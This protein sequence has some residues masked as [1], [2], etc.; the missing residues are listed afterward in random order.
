MKLNI[1]VIPGDGAGPEMVLPALDIL[2]IIS[3]RYGHILKLTEVTACGKGIEEQGSPLPEE[4]QKVCLA[5]DA[6]LLGNVG[7][8]KYQDNPFYLRPEYGL[9]KLR[10]C[11]KVTTNIRPVRLYAPLCSL[12]PLKKEVTERGLDL[13][14][15][16]DIAGGV[17]CS[18]QVRQ[19]GEHGAE[20]YEYEYYNVDIVWDTAKIAFE[21]AGAR[22]KKLLSLD[23]ANVLESSRLWRKT[24]TQMGEHYPG[25]QLSHGY[26]D[27]AALKLVTHPE[28]F[29]VVVT[30]N[31]FGDIIS[32]EGTGL[33]GTPGLYASAELSVK[34]PGLYTPNQLHHPDET[35][36]G[37][38]M[39]CPVGMIAAVAL[40]LR[41]SFGL[42]EE[43]EAVEK[44]IEQVLEEGYVTADLAEKNLEKKQVVGTAVM[45]EMIARKIKEG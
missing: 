26:I 25:I 12:P 9:L 22:K 34:G 8:K 13:I 6:V 44:G 7:L 39:V 5:S 31:L 33:T 43:A 27:S 2:R 42:E 18:E 32:D 1:A 4:A 36:I 30:S 38:Q 23:K 19:V 11:L 37:K 28:E 16:R 3:R 29:D 20:A 41:C 40:M 45:G 17:L 24:V 21:I 15:V 14:F 10:R 35:M